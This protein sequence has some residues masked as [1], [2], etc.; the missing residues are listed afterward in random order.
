VAGV[1]GRSLVPK[2][3]HDVS[4]KAYVRFGQA[5]A[6][7]RL[8]PG[9]IM[10]GASRAGTTS[11]F[12]G[13]SGHPQVLRPAVNKGVR[14]FDLN[15]TR[16]WDWYM[17]H[18]PMTRTAERAAHGGAPMAFEASGYYVF[19]PFAPERIARDL[20]D[21]KLVVML[22]DP[23]E[24]AYSAW[25]HESARGFEWETFERALELEDERLEGEVERMARDA[26]YES[27][28]H[29]HLSHRSRGEY[30]DQL[31]RILQVVPREQ[32]HIMQS[33]AFFVAPQEEFT[34]LTRFLGLSDHA[35]KSFEVH[36]ARPSS[37]MP[38][39]V[40]RQLEEHFAPYDARLEALLGEPLR[41]AR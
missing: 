21:T 34:A 14:Y 25:K 16:G 41:W 37:P 9:F 2:G 29:R 28:C 15:Y 30:V 35:P 13:L 22:R 18:F 26:T 39:D 17:G 11:L 24:R 6:G 1:S 4:R 27:F 19:H 3:L 33:E 23:V 20:P 40:R 31:E 12:R 8:R 36:N 38:A 7:R 10:M 32:L 5:T